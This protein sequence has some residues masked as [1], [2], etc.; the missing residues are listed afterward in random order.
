MGCNVQKVKIKNPKCFVLPE[1]VFNFIQDSNEERQR[2]LRWKELCEK[3]G[4]SIN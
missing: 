4:Q 2:E 3:L 1:E